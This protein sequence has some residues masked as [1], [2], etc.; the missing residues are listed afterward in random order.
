[1][2]TVPLRYSFHCGTYISIPL[3]DV[4][5]ALVSFDDPL[6]LAEHLGGLHQVSQL[7]VDVAQGVGVGG[8][9]GGLGR[10]LTP[11][12]TDADMWE[13]GMSDTDLSIRGLMVSSLPSLMVLPSW[14]L[15]IGLR[16]A[17]GKKAPASPAQNAP[18][19]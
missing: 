8:P 19:F 7:E 16:T 13:V 12:F 2:N 1:M 14:C 9:A 6:H 17:S 3:G 11:A 10:G 15:L 4:H 5:L 18:S